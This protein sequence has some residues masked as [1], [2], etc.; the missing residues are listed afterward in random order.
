MLKNLLVALA[1]AAGLAGC[2]GGDSA[3]TPEAVSSSLKAQANALAAPTVSDAANQLM[4]FGEQTFPFL[5]PHGPNTIAA[6]GFLFRFYP[7][8]GLFLGVVV[9]AASPFGL[10]NV[11]VVGPGFGTLAE[12]HLVGPL[13]NF[14]TPVDPNPNPDPGPVMK[15]L[16]ITVSGPGFAPVTVDLGVSAFPTTQSEFCSEID[17]GTIF[18]QTLADSGFSG[19]LTITSCSFSGNSG[20]VG[21]TVNVTAPVVASLPISITYTFQ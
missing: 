17:P 20:T 3:A 2:G 4:D 18:N 10:N 8:T 6:A 15:N 7:Q 12:P 1:L 19:N 11:Y 21:A 14:I 9:D 5:F 16:S 13:T